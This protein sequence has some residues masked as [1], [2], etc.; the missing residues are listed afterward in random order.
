MTALSVFTYTDREVRTILID[1]EPWFV[2][3]DVCRVLD[4]GNS[5]MVRDR[6]DEDGVSQTDV[7][8]SMGRK[9][10]ATIVDESGL[11]EV[12]L[13][14]DKPG[15]RD[16]RRWVTREVLPQIRR[17][18]QYGGVAAVP[19]S[20]AEALELAARQQRELEAAEA[21][22]LLD[23][24]KVESYEAFMTAAGHY[25]MEAAAK[26]L[27][28]VTGGMGRNQ[29]FA[30]LREQRIL[31]PN[32]S[33]YQRYAHWFKVVVGSYE[34]RRGVEHATKTTHVRPEGLDALRRRFEVGP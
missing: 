17:T 27:A 8:D 33:P 19:Q 15:A 12:I 25:T 20:F 2:L 10:T 14:S 34:D 32:N 6:L 24:P 31:M 9:Q 7:I 16:F 23:A 18:G 13:R 11:Y 26:S 22:R 4:I 3:S 5:R 21:Q 28:D 30:W 1:G 29:L